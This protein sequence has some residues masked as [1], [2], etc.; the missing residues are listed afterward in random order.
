MKFVAGLTCHL[1]GAT[2][3]PKASWVCSDC[4]GPL[5][6]SYDYDAV[7]KVISRELIESRPGS[8]WR[9]VELLP[10]QGFQQ[11]PKRAL[12][13]GLTLIRGK[14]VLGD[15]DG[16]G[17]D[18]FGIERTARAGNRLGASQLRQRP[19]PGQLRPQPGPPLAHPGPGVRG[20]GR[21]IHGP[22]AGI[23]RHHGRPG[24]RARCQNSRRIHPGSCRPGRSPRGG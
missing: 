1:C 14:P 24:D 17:Q 19:L 12:M 10:V 7:R 23:R 20:T 2:Y 5:E 16:N 21:G 8:L 9:Y 3:P 18:G 6:V 11:L 15:W 4:L 22:A 13:P